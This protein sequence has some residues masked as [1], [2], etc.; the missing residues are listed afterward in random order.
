MTF[1]MWR[2]FPFRRAQGPIIME[3]QRPSLRESQRATVQK[4]QRTMVQDSTDSA[5]E[6][7]AYTYKVSAKMNNISMTIWG[8]LKKGT[9]RI[10]NSKHCYTF[11]CDPKTFF[12]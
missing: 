3:S 2:C 9:L 6:V 8:S 12:K 4:S 1:R 10:L 7:R 5:W 11:N